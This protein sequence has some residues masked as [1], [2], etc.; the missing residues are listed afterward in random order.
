LG[1][2]ILARD[3]IA[4]GPDYCA[5]LSAAGEGLR[6]PPATRAGR[7]PHPAIAV[8]QWM[9]VHPWVCVPAERHGSER[10]EEKEEEA[11]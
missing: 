6:A 8:D 4:I 3:S 2:Q 1:S 11:R 9:R 10:E 7:P 5:K